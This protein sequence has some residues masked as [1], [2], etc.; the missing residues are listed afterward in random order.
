MTIAEEGVDAPLLQIDSDK[1][2][3][4]MKLDISAEIAERIK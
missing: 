4:D 3:G 2:Y 1:L